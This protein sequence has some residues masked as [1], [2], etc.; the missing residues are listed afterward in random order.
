MIQWYKQCQLDLEKTWSENKELK[1]ENI[2]L[3]DEARKLLGEN[4]DLSK[5]VWELSR[6]VLYV[7][8]WWQKARELSKLLWVY[9]QEIEDKVREI[10]GGQMPDELEH[11][12]EE[13]AQDKKF[14]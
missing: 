10:L 5:V 9:N 13:S 4:A 12:E 14:F 1:D 11:E 6:Y 2:I 8:E 7:K 3:K